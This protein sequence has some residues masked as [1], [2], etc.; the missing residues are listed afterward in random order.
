MEHLSCFLPGA[1]W[2]AAHNS[3]PPTLSETFEAAQC[4]QLAEDL[5]FTCWQMC[6]L[7][8]QLFLAK[9]TAKMHPG[10]PMQT[11]ISHRY[12]QTATGIGPEQVQFSQ[13]RSLRS[14]VGLGG[15]KDFSVSKAMPWS[16]MRPEVVESLYVAFHLTGDTKYQVR[17]L[18]SNVSVS[19]LNGSKLTTLTCCCGRTGAG[20]S[21]KHLKSTAGQHMALARAWCS[22]LCFLV[23]SVVS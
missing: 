7:F 9:D 8:L 15:G 20:K 6:V 5:M 22:D 16:T 3:I 1:L 23:L 10:S 18:H 4:T 19:A 12:D 14:A 13:S 17:S 11:V 2:L 21:I